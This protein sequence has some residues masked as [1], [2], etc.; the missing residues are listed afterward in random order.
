ME[1][2]LASILLT[3]FII[4]SKMEESF[5]VNDYYFDNFKIFP[6]WYFLPDESEDAMKRKYKI[7]QVSK[8]EIFAEEYLKY[9]EENK[10]LN[11]SFSGY[12]EFGYHVQ[13]YSFNYTSAKKFLEENIRDLLYKKHQ[14]ISNRISV[15][16]NEIIELINYNPEK[17]NNDI[18]IS[19]KNISE[20]LKQV[21]QD[22]ILKP[23]I[24]KLQSI[25]KYLDDVASINTNYLRIFKTLLIPIKTE[26]IRSVKTTVIWAIISILLTTLFAILISIYFN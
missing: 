15:L 4:K 25:T 1:I 17:I 3:D 13:I 10:F 20:I 23:L 11:Y 12:S 2:E 6:E 24:F 21:D 7:F 5:I 16:K 22:D 8:W 26:G 14:E 18:A 19:K 9:F